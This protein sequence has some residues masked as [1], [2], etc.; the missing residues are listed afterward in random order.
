MEL[1]PTHP[2]RLGLALNFSV[3]LYEILNSPD[4]AARLATQALEEAIVE[5]DTLSEESCND[6]TSLVNLIKNNLYI[7]TRELENGCSEDSKAAEVL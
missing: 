5:L 2:I 7:W 4:R 3:F 1:L 6:S